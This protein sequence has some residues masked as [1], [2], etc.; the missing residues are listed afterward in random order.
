[1]ILKDKAVIMIRNAEK[2]DAEKI[3]AIYS[4]YVKNTAISFELDV[5]SLDEFQGRIVRTLERY[6][7]LV[8][9]EKGV[10][11]GYAYAGVFK[12]RAA[13]DHCCE[14]S[15]YVERHAK[16]RGYGRMLYEALETALKK[17]G[18]LYLYACI[19]DP[20]TE[21]EYLTRNSEHFHSHLGYTMVGQFHNCGYKFN[22]WYNMIWMEKI[23]G[24]HQ[25]N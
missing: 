12:N 13:Y 16:G 21:D 1:M 7:Y 17:A 10:I 23:I 4:Y 20:V 6:P 25:K 3:L 19:A 15:I 11:L 22:R 8:L 5:P 9:E 18:I 14:V 24:E 2:E